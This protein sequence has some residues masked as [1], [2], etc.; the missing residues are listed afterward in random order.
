MSILQ[1]KD[2]LN[3]ADEIIRIEV[4]AL[5]TF[6]KNLDESIYNLCKKIFEAK[7]KV[8]VIGVGK[9]GHIGNKIA[10][11]LSS[12][13]TPAIFVHPSEAIHGDIGVISK[14]DII[15]LISN[16][17]STPEILSILPNLKKKGCKIMSLC[18]NTNSKIYEESEISVCISVKKEACPHNLAPTASTTT[19]LVAGDVIA[20]IL[21][22][23]KNFE[24]KNFGENHPG[25]KLGKTLNLRVNNLMCTG[26]DIPIL[27]RKKMLKEAVFEMTK[28]NLGCVVISDDK[29]KA[30]G[31]FTDGDLRRTIKN[32][33]DIHKTPIEKIM[34]KKFLFCFKNDYATDALAKMKKNKIN[35]M[36]VLDKNKKIIGAINMH[37]LVNS[38]I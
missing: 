11:T 8:I 5:N 38:G 13:G 28:K 19:A 15:L 37:I 34:N 29:N 10:A 20:I 1:K 32:L 24:A 27:H 12:T 3:L 33:T 36:P 2:I 25:G 23:M 18:G 9:S 22:K 16:S 35:S 26:K 6:K 7:G 14:L 30:I 31:F 21:M 17:G 4:S